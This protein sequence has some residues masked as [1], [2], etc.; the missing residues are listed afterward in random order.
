MFAFSKKLK[1]IK[2]V[3]LAVAPELHFESE[4]GVTMQPSSLVNVLWP[5][6]HEPVLAVPQIRAK[7]HDHV[8]KLVKVGPRAE[9]RHCS[10]LKHA[11]F[12]R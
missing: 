3:F 11:Y 7:L 9:V 2:G 1:D 6:S 12:F 8:C 5:H 4:V 10:I